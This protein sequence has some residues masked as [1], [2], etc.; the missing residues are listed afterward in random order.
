MIIRTVWTDDNCIACGLCVS[1]CSNVFHIINNSC[2]IN[3]KVRNDNITNNNQKDKSCLK[4]DVQLDIVSA[5]T[6][7]AAMC[8]TQSIHVQTEDIKNE[9]ANQTTQGIINN[10]TNNNGTNGTKN[11]ALFE[12]NILST[13]HNSDIPA[14]QQASQIGYD[15]VFPT[16][17]CA[18][19][20]DLI[21]I[22]NELGNKVEDIIQQGNEITCQIA[23]EFILDAL[24][25]C[26][27]NICL[28]YEMLTDQT[29]THYPDAE[30]F[31]FSVVYQLTSIS[32][33]KRLRLR[34][35]IQDGFEP[36]SATSIY[37]AANWLE[38]EIWDMLGIKFKNHPNMMRLLC[39]ENWDGHPLRKDY[40]LI[41][42]GQRNIDFR[43]DRSG[44]LMRTAM[45]KS[46]NIIFNTNPPE[47]K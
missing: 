36:D 15:M 12:T 32:R 18:T 40:P 1:E 30:Q 4:N 22:K 45:Q 11:H 27:D 38:R 34:I 43:E 41:G 46:E 7:S 14:K 25:L 2:V 21:F 19:D 8:P 44:V 3:A 29:A 5:I 47:A 35:L 24:L 28:C 23:K 9:N 31:D 26:R 16:I 37:P 20:M 33:N 10:F 42:L 13:V 17:I 6:K 39:P